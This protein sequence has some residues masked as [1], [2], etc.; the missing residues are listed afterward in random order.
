M[1]SKLSLKKDQLRTWIEIDKKAV[2]HNY[3]LF[4]SLVPKNTLVC[5]V[6]KSNA[7]GHGLTE[8]S[9]IA[10]RHVDMFSVDSAIEGIRLRESGI[11]KPIF[12]LG[13]TL[14]SLLTEVVKNDIDITIAGKKALE[15]AVKIKKKLNIHLKIDTGMS[16][17][18]FFVKDLKEVLEM[19]KKNK[20]LNLKGMY[21]HFADAKNPAFPDSTYAQMSNFKRAIN[22]VHKNGFDPIIHCA[23]TS[24]IIL[25][26]ETHFDMVRIG[27]GSY[28]LWPDEKVKAYASDFLDL[29]PV[30]KWKTILADTK[31]IPKGA[32]VSYGLTEIVKKKTKIGILPIGYWHGY[33]RGLSSIGYVLINGKKAK[34]LGRV[35]MD[36][37]IIDLSKVKNAKEGDEVVLLGG[38]ISADYIADLLNT[39][40]YEVVTRINPKIRRVAI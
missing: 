14:P 12:V 26:P 4:K 11:L 36:I 6:V 10:N 18:G 28:G 5:G 9:K 19:F 34:V 37:V 31:E 25:F 13:Y 29:K 27:I 7:Y 15:E 3:K 24:S 30:L 8:F 2:A 16:R 38:K 40:N 1:K 33:D 39:I 17:Q 32:G 20:H 23:A 21:T 22:I 35:T